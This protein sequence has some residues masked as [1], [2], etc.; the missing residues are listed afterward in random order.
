MPRVKLSDA[1]RLAKNQ[2]RVQRWRA[3]NKK[4]EEG[5]L[6][7]VKTEDETR[8]PENK[9]LSRER[10]RRYRERKKV[11]KEE[12]VD[13]QHIEAPTE[14]G[15][16]RLSG[17]PSQPPLTR[18]NVDED[19]HQDSIDTIT[20]ILDDLVVGKSGLVNYGTQSLFHCISDILTDISSIGP[21]SII[22]DIHP[23]LND[24][25]RRSGT[26]EGTRDEENQKSPPL[27]EDGDKWYLPEPEDLSEWHEDCQAAVYDEIIDLQSPG[28]REYDEEE[29]A[30]EAKDEIYVEEDTQYPLRQPEPPISTG[31]IYDIEAYSEGLATSSQ[32]RLLYNHPVEDPGQ[33]KYSSAVSV[34]QTAWQQ[35]CTCGMC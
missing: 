4:D 28:Q 6:R 17:G 33:S 8:V 13:R 20:K 31:L 1:E 3:K 2:E 12:D 15:N 24:K 7:P 35:K 19:N 9:T 23:V 14:L 16:A 11:V 27:L 32:Q 34:L 18:P 29:E 21:K 25:E 5:H 30:T 26:P 22:S 10:S